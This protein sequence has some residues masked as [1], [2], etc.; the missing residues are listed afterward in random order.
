MEHYTVQ[1]P[2]TVKNKPSSFV[3]LWYPTARPLQ[4]WRKTILPSCVRYETPLKNLKTP[5][6]PCNAGNVISFSGFAG[7]SGNNTKRYI[8]E[9][10]PKPYFSNNYQYMRNRGNTFETVSSRHKLQGVQYFEGKNPIWPS[11]PQ[12][13]GTTSASFAYSN[14]VCNAAKHVIYKP[15]NTPFSTQ[16][17]VD[18]STRLWKLKYA[19]RP[20][21]TQFQKKALKVK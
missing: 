10:V 5:S 4:L 19:E 15:S 1:S 18:S 14:V 13:N 11:T 12:Q 9:F 2:V 17:A 20:E 7:I 21:L 8:S 3:G 6:N 16:G